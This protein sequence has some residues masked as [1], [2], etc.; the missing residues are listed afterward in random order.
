MIEVAGEEW[1][2][3]REVADRIGQGVTEDA[4]RWWGRDKGLAKARTTDDEGKPQ[5][6]YMVSQAVR[7]DVAIRT[8][9]R[10]RRRAA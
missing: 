3:A 9:G 1:G 4:V 8:E 6:R 10:G 2:T 7:I 5:V